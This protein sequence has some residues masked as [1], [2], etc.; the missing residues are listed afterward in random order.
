MYFAKEGDETKRKE[1]GKGTA[2]GRKAV[3]MLPNQ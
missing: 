3:D 1:K 2:D